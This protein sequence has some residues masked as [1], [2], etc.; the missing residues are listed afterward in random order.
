MLRH[1]YRPKYFKLH[2]L[3][4]P[5]LYEKYKNNHEYLWRLLD[6][7]ALEALDIVKDFYNGASVTVNNY[8]W[9]GKYKESGLRNPFAKTGATLSAHKFGGAFDIKVKGVEASQVQSDIKNNRLPARF[10]E[11]VNCVERDTPTW[12]HIAHLNYV[13]DGIVWVNG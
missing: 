3:V 4:P 8:F 1:G 7:K 6:A 12:T 2:E 11:C 5:E 10:Y 9:G 13:C